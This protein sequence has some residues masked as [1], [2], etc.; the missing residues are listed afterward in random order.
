MSSKELKKWL[1]RRRESR[2]LKRIREHLVLVNSCIMKGKEF[3]RFWVNKNESAASNLYDLIHQE[4][5]TADKIEA[6]IV[7]MLSEGETPE[8]VRTD[9]LNF[10]K[11]ADKVAGSVKRGS[12]NLLLLIKHN[13]PG[14]I[15]EI[16]GIIYDLLGEEMTA[17]IKVFDAMFKVEYEELV[18]LISA[19][20]EIESSIDEAY[21][22]LKYEIAY[23]TENV[24]AGA[25]I[26]LDH[27][28]KDLEAT[29]DLIEDCSDLLSSIVLI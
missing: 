14:S 27:A 28:I 24:P 8:Y 1:S 4:E 16:L 26:I 19:V 25:L 2:I 20:D 17:F 23:S 6:D 9:L 13:L 7:V 10:I 15:N 22:K 5:K 3:Y 21:K 12:N 11:M 29:S 18:R